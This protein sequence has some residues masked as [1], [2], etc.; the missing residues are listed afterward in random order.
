MRELPLRLSHLREFAEQSPAHYAYG[1]DKPATSSMEKGTATHALVFDTRKVVAAP[2]RRG[3]KAF[4]KFE[5][6][7]PDT[8][9]L[10]PKAFEAARAMA[11]ALLGNKF[12][13][14][15]LSRARKSGGVEQRLLWTCNGVPCRV[16][17]DLWAPG[18]VADVKTSRTAK[19][20]W[21]R[22]DALKLWYHAYLCWGA[23]ALRS[24]GHG[25]PS[26]RYLFVVE[27]APPWVVTVFRLSDSA[28]DA[29][30]KRWR[31]AFE[32]WKASYESNAWPPYSEAI[33]ELEADVLEPTFPDEGEV[34][35]D[36]EATLETATSES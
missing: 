2:C 29:G 6:E 30:T 13:A 24:L 21:F 22:R 36:E 20:E 12:F 26:Q 34:E 8:E 31:S 11:D 23:E 35:D 3:T 32:L 9:I 19:P 1:V 14:E 4:D 15:A 25:E 18:I 16:T 10:P 33:V 27:S 28:I 5:A 7:N 17:P